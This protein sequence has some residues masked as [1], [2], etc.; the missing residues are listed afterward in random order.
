MKIKLL[1]AIFGGLPA[2]CPNCRGV[3]YRGKSEVGTDG[4]T[5]W[6]QIICNACGRVLIFTPY[7]PYSALDIDKNIMRQ[8]FLIKYFDDT[9]GVKLAIELPYPDRKGA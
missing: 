5:T 8:V 9:Q 3:D 2:S 1:Q 6:F 7:Q 4:A